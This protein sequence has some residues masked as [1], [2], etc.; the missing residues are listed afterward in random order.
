[1]HQVIRAIVYAESEED[2]LDCARGV[3]EGVCGDDGPFDYFQMFDGPGTEVSGRGRW[4]NVTPVARADSPE[5]KQLI[6][7]GMEATKH[8]MFSNLRHIRYGLRRLTDEDIWNNVFKE[9]YA[10]SPSERT[11]GEILSDDP[12]PEG[13]SLAVQAPMLRHFMYNVGRYSGSPYWLYDRDGQP[14]R[15]AP[16]VECVL[17]KWKML[18]EDQGKPNPYKDLDVWVVTADVHS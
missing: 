1:M 5:G 13:D 10:L 7:E 12:E 3:F 17:S 2:A 4:G 8:E 11:I 6:A 18:Y 9:P 14:I 16:A 15:E